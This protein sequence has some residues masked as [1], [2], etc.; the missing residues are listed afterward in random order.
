MI[1]V[2]YKMTKPQVNERPVMGFWPID[3]EPK[4]RELFA[5]RTSRML[6]L[7]IKNQHLVNQ[8]FND[9]CI[10]LGKAIDAKLAKGEELTGRQLTRWLQNGG[11]LGKDEFGD[12]LLPYV[13]GQK[14]ILW[15]HKDI[16]LARWAAFGDRDSDQ[17]QA[18]LC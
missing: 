11:A 9:T 6:W 16:D 1:K 7:G 18:A 3:A 17:F 14:T 12:E 5:S 8:H 2:S 4:I 10:R 13:L 15:I